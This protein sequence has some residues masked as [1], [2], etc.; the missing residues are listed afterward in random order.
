MQTLLR[1]P[2]VMA[3]TALARPTL[4]R[5]IKRGTFPKP[6]KLGRASAWPCDAV[7]AVIAARIAG[8]TDDEIR[9]LVAELER[10]RANS[11]AL[12]AS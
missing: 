12:A 10:N 5:D 4:Y 6:V 11:K 8:K 3:A 9:A 1:M 7:Q 2:D